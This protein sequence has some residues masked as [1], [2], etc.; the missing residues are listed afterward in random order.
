MWGVGY[1]P[2]DLA[3]RNRPV[4]AN[5]VTE[6]ATTWVKDPTITAEAVLIEIQVCARLFMVIIYR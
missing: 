1:Y 3:A 5:A 4:N 2:K 6:M